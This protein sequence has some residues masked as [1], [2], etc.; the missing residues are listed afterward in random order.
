M[1]LGLSA[2]IRPSLTHRL[3]HDKSILVLTVSEDRIY[4]GT[5]NGEILV[6]SLK[7]YERIGHIQAHRG[8]VLGL[9]LREKETIIF[10]SAADRIV[11]VW[12][13]KTL[14]RL[15][16]IYSTYDIGDVFCVCYSSKS[17]T[18][19]LGAQNTT[20][21]WYDLR[22]KDRRPSPRPSDHPHYRQDRF[23]DSTGPGGI[24]TPRLE[25]E[26]DPLEAHGGQAL[27]IDPQSIH[28][29][30]HYGY[31]YCMVL[32]RG[33]LPNAP[34]DE[35]VLVS[36]GGDGI[37][38]VWS[39][40]GKGSGRIHELYTLED[41]REEGDSV[42]SLV[43]DGAFLYTGRLDGDVNVWDLETRQLVRTLRVDV[44]D[45]LTMSVGGGHLFTG[46][47]N[48]T[49]EKFN[50]QYERISKFQ[51]HG[52]RILCSA[53]INLNGRPV[54]VTGSN[55]STIA[56]W[57]IQDCI[58]VGEN[59]RR[60]HSDYLLESLQEFVSYRTV[61]S[62]SR[63]K[64]DCHRGASFL[65]SVL[66]NFGATTESLKSGD[67]FNPVIYGRFRG[68]PQTA[69]KRKKI[70]FYGHY[71]VIAA[72]NSQGKWL[73]EPF[74]LSGIDGH[75]YGRGVSDNKG[76]I[77]AAIYAAAQ[78]NTSQ[79]LESDIIFIIEGEEE[80]GSRGFAETIRRNRKLI[81]DVD[82]ILLANSYWLDDDVPC[83]TY[84]LRGVIHATVQVE[85]AHPDL[86]SGVDGSALLDESLKDL[87]LLLSKLAGPHGHVEIPGFYEPIL[88]LTPEELEL[89]NHITTT[90]IR[91]DPDLGDPIQLATSLMRRWRE[92]SL[93]IHRFHTSGPENSTIIPRLARAA[94]SLRLVPNQSAEAIS[95]QL[96]SFLQEQFASLGSQNKLTVAI[97][98]RAE[99][100][101]GD[102]HNEIY[103]TLE[104][105]LVKSW[106]DQWG[107]RRSSFHAS[108]FAGAKANGDEGA[109]KE[110]IPSTGHVPSP[111]TRP[112]TSST[113]SRTSTRVADLDTA[114]QPAANRSG[115]AAA[116]ESP[117][118][119]TSRE[120]A[121]FA[122]PLYIREGGSI[123]AI[124][125]LET[126]FD[127]PAAQLP[128][129]QASD[130][131]HLDNER[132]RLVN[133]M[134]GKEV[135]E[136]VFRE[137]PRR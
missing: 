74:T 98:H 76:P 6:F 122:R 43:L 77:M 37:V 110:N 42:L 53:F 12:C 94:I 61:S 131:A 35:E 78:L 121:P 88:K 134:K 113:L 10:S 72:D 82:W 17:K 108:K 135:F 68:N 30:A 69:T 2:D 102:V 32:A 44:G 20:I 120:P 1:S 51:A 107:R 116:P 70:L 24:R 48:G 18:V 101:L 4:A 33:I 117:I 81:G 66:K 41:G 105:G 114:S 29:F 91:R 104:E 124:R 26:D 103:Q 19:Y 123:P 115:N 132:I 62:D 89:Y 95:Q 84:G 86:H 15:Y 75:L 93:T 56:V 38:K 118:A 128:I 9:C 13:T 39:L 58:D 8:S 23:F 137:L 45:V 5:Q 130:S 90:L 14:R 36:G 60:T 109:K 87:V 63:F 125:F 65:R 79:A 73:R 57:D 83:L 111:T 21:Q 27:E 22:E 49:V 106:G 71:D 80:C 52:G 46:G 59:K 136:Y 133:L 50:R 47:V 7:S 97:D 129:G 127:A 25:V 40:N 11:N 92:A 100:W 16:S 119:E 67:S 96:E 3:I 31:V 99:P 126:E 64:G 54:F 34:A 112:A 55:D 28:Q 85:S